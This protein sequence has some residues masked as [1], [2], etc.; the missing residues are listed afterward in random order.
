MSATAGPMPMLAFSHAD[1]ERAL[2]E[3]GANCGPG[4]LAAVLSLPLA[5]VRHAI[6]DFERRRYTSPTMMRA[7]LA[8]LRVQIVRDERD[9]ETDPERFPTHGLVRVQWEGPWTVPGS[10]PRWAYGRTHWV[11]SHA[12]GPGAMW[13]FDINA[14]WTPSDYWAA[15]VVPSLT[16]GY[17]R[18]TGQWW[19][20]HRWTVGR[21]GL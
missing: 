1:A 12:N 2:Q 15:I 8:A 17:A 11:A 20:T 16:I 5:A 9:R 18:A 19:A 10:N 13:I 6:P 14:G 4:A 3:W 21:G 7:A